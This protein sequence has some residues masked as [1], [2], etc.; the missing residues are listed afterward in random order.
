MY[1]VSN[2]KVYWYDNCP[3]SVIPKS[4]VKTIIRKLYAHKNCRI[5]INHYFLNHV[6]ANF[7][8]LLKI[9]GFFGDA[10]SSI[11]PSKI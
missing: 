9:T 10:I 5:I 7:C 6:G 2:D 8:R 4:V 3:Q 11:I 1:A